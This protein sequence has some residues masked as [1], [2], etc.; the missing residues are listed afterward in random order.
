MRELLY[1]SNIQSNSE[2]N[3]VTTHD[4]DLSDMICIPLLTPVLEGNV[5][6]DNLLSKN[7]VDLSTMYDN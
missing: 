6:G 4:S 1:V 5:Y 7:D 3:A 2:Q